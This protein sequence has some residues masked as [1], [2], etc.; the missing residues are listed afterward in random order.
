MME[1]GCVIVLT[2]IASTADGHALASTLVDERLAAC[3]NLLGEMD[4]I[5]RWQGAVETE[6]ER[7]VII[8][9]TAA[10]VEALRARLHE[11]HSYDV[12]EF[13]VVPIVGGSEPYLGWLRNESA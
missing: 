2:T 10:K 11:L 3:V 7:Q 9:T 4:S 5:Y 1:T 6:R 8:K 12:P 13:L